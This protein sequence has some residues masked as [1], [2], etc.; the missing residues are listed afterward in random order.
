MII[1]KSSPL[2]TIGLL[3]SNRRDTI[4]KCLDSLAPIREAVPCELVI[5]DTGCDED[6]HQLLQ[7]Y[8]D[9]LHCFTWCNDF[10]KARNANLALAEGQ[11]YL[12]LDDD[13]WFVDVEEIIDFFQSG[14]YRN[15]GYASYIQ[16]NFV[17]MQGVQYSDSWVS[18]MIR[19]GEHT[20]FES[21]IHE[22]F[23]PLSGN[24]KGL[25]AIVHHYGYVFESEEAQRKH[26]ERNRVLLEE[27]IA[28]EPNELRWRIQL[29]QEYRP[30][31]EFDRLYKLGEESLKLAEGR[32][33]L[34]ERIALGSFYAAKILALKEQQNY[35]E[36]EQIC[37]EAE[38]DV[39]NTE[40][41][42]AFLALEKADV[43]FRLGEYRRAEESILGYL[44]WEA[45]FRENEP[46]FFLQEGTAFIG[47]S[48]DD[49]MKKR[50]YS[51]LIA[52]GLHLEKTDY[53]KEYFSCLEWDKPFVYIYDGIMEAILDTFMR[54]EAEPVF[55]QV[56]EQMFRHSVLREQFCR[57]ILNSV[58]ECRWE[59]EKVQKRHN[60][61]GLQ[62][63][64]QAEELQGL[65][66][67]QQLGNEQA[68][69]EIQS[70]QEPQQP[71]RLWNLIREMEHGIYIKNNL[72]L[73]KKYYQ[74]YIIK[75]YPELLSASEQVMLLAQG[76]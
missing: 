74:E 64:Q 20:H 28:E 39:R 45:F 24:C 1:R 56:L 58:S 23:A 26:Y 73:V 33:T 49:V 61:Q 35:P 22:Y 40:L 43:C 34:A 66:D 21:K 4:Q 30:I 48:F 27:M 41:C 16:R 7:E 67:P 29:A 52:A 19:R 15:Y 6:L 36:A 53:L 75:E 60:A 8:A 59:S 9:K 63:L 10:A 32:S 18:R 65:Q 47:E 13:E 62:E 50:G 76:D 70:L 54:R 25:H 31:G 42:R 72:D 44:K 3:V 2:L 14:D 51:I 69:Q 11:W 68:V 71:E 37:R 46:L 38:E 57:V 55:Y 12:Y 17:D 5:T